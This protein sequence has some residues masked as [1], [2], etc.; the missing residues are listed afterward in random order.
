MGETET[1]AL[2]A[3]I[4]PKKS[5]GPSFQYFHVQS[6]IQR[7]VEM[8]G[9]FVDRVLGVLS[10]KDQWFHN[11]YALLLL[12]KYCWPILSTLL[13]S[14]YNTNPEGKFMNKKVNTTGMRSIILA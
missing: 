4:R 3:P 6:T 12:I 11:F 1:L 9:S 5:R 14:Q 7:Q 2:R 10:F 8:H 13:T